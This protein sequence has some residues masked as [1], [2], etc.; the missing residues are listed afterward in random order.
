MLFDSENSTVLILKNY[1]TFHIIVL[2]I[3]HF[4]VDAR[5]LGEVEYVDVMQ[6]SSEA[7]LRCSTPT[8]AE[9]LVSNAP[10]QQVD[11]LKGKHC[12]MLKK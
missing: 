10:W 12:V 5:A 11:I 1:V 2:K 8:A 4:Q 7:F 6:G 9:L 3:Y